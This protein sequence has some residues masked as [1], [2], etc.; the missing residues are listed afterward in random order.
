MSREKLPVNMNWKA[1]RDFVSNHNKWFS[2]TLDDFYP[3]MKKEDSPMN[4]R[5]IDHL[6]SDMDIEG[7]RIT[8]NI[9]DGDPFLGEHK[10]YVPTLNRLIRMKY[11]CFFKVAEVDYV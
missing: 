4:M 8:L 11:D 3:K 9:Q 7:E 10:V 1:F 5:R 2:E 6:M